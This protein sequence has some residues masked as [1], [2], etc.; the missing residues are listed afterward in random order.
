LKYTKEVV[1]GLLFILALAIF[2]W[3]YNFLKGINVFSKEKEVFGI[4]EKVDGLMK[5]NPV[6][7][8]GMKIGHVK[9]LW[10]AEDFSGHIV[11]QMTI[12]TDFPVP[13][14]SIA[15]IYSSDLMGSKAI[16]IELGNDPETLGNGDT[17]LT[18]IEAGIK[19]EVNKQ[20]QPLKRKAEN[21]IISI[22][23]MVTAIQTVFNEN[24][25]ENLIESF[26]DIKST[27]ANL[28]N[29]T[30]QL[31]TFIYTEKNHLSKIIYNIEMMTDDL[32]ENKNHINQVLLNMR[33]ISDSLAA[34]DIPGTFSHAKNSLEEL[35]IILE[36]VN[37]SEGTLGQLVNDKDLYKQLVNTTEALE[38][39]LKDVKENPKKFVK[40]SVF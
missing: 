17:L 25:R 8:N 38:E 26:Q 10:F 4:Y 9:N 34:A 28:Q 16:E 21:L 36:K 29:T 22:D 33:T 6:S 7:I 35:G 20:V 2:F 24:A 39:L 11:V 30:Y 1:V 27:F 23:S 18:S 15:H 5:S 12:N 37:K 13:K 32:R 40:F 19:E 3:G 31:D 14:N